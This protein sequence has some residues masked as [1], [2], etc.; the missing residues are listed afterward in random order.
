MVPSGLLFV[1]IN[2]ALSREYKDRRNCWRERK[3]LKLLAL[4]VHPTARSLSQVGLTF[5]W[6]ASPNKT[7]LTRKLTPCPLM[8]IWWWLPINVCQI[9]AAIAVCQSRR[10][11]REDGA[12]VYSLTRARGEKTIRASKKIGNILF[13]NTFVKT[14]AVTHVIFTPAAMH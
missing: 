6:N 7:Q 5:D 1:T 2:L 10:V 9:P 11:A 13:M 3:H 12:A 8:A 14:L 4:P